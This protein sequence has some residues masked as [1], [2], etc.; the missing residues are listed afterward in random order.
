MLKPQSDLVVGSADTE[1]RAWRE[2]A[3][4]IVL[5]AM[6]LV[7]GIASAGMAQRAYRD[8]KLWQI[9]CLVG[10]YG[11]LAAVTMWQ[12]APHSVRVGV[13]LSVL[14][15]TGLSVL[16]FS[17]DAGIGLS[18]LL[19]VTFL[20]P[21]LVG[22]RGA[23]VWAGLCIGAL[24]VGA[25]LLAFGRRALA[26]SWAVGAGEWMDWVVMGLVY[27][28]LA[29]LVLLPGEHLHR[30]LINGLRQGSRLVGEIVSERTG[31]Q[32]QIAERTTQL[33]LRAQ[34]LEAITELTHSATVLLDDPQTLLERV[35]DLI[36]ERLAF[37]HTAVFLVDEDRNWLDLRAASSGEGRHMLGQGY[38][39]PLGGDGI[40]GRVAT[41]GVAQ[42][43]RG[44]GPR[45]TDSPSPYLASTRSE[46]A[47]PLRVRGETVGVLDVHSSEPSAFSD[48]DVA[49]L[50]I[51]TDQLAVALTNARLSRQVRDS[52]EAMRKA[53]GEVGLEMWRSLLRSDGEMSVRH[54]PR[55]A[56]S[57][58]GLSGMA[59]KA[60]CEA[61]LVVE[62]SEPGAAAVP[63][64]VR[65]GHVI[66]VVNA[67][68][69]G[70]EG[71]WKPEELELL[72]SL[73]DQLGVALDGA[74]LYQESQQRAERE[75][76]VAEISA[77]M[78]ETLS[79]DAVLR[80]AI[81]EIRD[82]MGFAEVEV[83]MRGEEEAQR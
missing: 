77:R 25:A 31:L 32:L 55:G 17:G 62:E 7:G 51:L 53:Y 38:R 69:P 24:L 83:R 75:R 42:V 35:V 54:D 15:G 37:H 41:E 45:A 70:E 50:Q 71:A 26:S 61:R 64:K 63:I 6:L 9:P 48:D 72:R 44:V 29:L 21:L 52:A 47:L 74:Q 46:L 78:R 11:V 14:Y 57:S 5:R 39:L 56:L 76:L 67:L 66:G 82:V 10:A 2:Q 20:A 81:R 18:V 33:E 68:K 34:Y 36:T 3:L 40:V 59:H 12:R 30:R 79:I 58:D 13:L 1:L 65:G 22:R 60:R 80:T 8:G 4:A 19:A 23:G 73:V 27:A 43:A 28:A 16:V 49:V